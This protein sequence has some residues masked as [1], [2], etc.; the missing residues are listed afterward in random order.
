MTRTE[1]DQAIAEFR[2]LASREVLES[3]SRDELYATIETFLQVILRQRDN[4]EQ[5]AGAV[6]RYISERDRDKLT[7]I[8]VDSKHKGTA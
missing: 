8:L 6:E 5:V 2:R 7:R 3:L 4:L 1:A